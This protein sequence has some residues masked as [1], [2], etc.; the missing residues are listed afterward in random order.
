MEKKEESRTTPFYQCAHAH[1]CEREQ[2]RKMGKRGKVEEEK[3][4]RKRGEE[5]EEERKEKENRCEREWGTHETRIA[6]RELT[7]NG[8]F[9]RTREMEGEREIIYYFY[10]YILNDFKFYL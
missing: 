3:V 4:K 1:T 5:G 2:Q 6:E 10:L 9:H 7:C 8:K